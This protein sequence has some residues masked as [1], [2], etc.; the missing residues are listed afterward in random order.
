LIF[1]ERIA[2]FAQRIILVLAKEQDEQIHTSSLFLLPSYFLSLSRIIPDYP[3]L[4]N[5]HFCFLTCEKTEIKAPA[6]IN[7]TAFICA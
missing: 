3:G 4:A 5:R 7:L 2:R 1:R 6:L